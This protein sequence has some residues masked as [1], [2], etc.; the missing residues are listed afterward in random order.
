MLSPCLLESISSFTLP[1]ITDDQNAT[2][3][4]KFLE[5]EDNQLMLFPKLR[6]AV[7]LL[8]YF[9]VDFVIVVLAAY[10]RFGLIY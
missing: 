3:F 5:I 9:Y 10:S 6:Y 4:S 2:Y 1:L 7:C 8:V